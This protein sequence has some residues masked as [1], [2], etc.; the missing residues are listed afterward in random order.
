[1]RN[2]LFKLLITKR[3]STQ[4]SAWANRK[5]LIDGFCGKIL[6]RSDDWR[7]S[8]GSEDESSFLFCQIYQTMNNLSSNLS[9]TFDSFLLKLLD[10]IPSLHHPFLLRL[11]ISIRFF[12]GDSSTASKTIDLDRGHN[13]ETLVRTVKD[14]CAENLLLGQ[15]EN[16]IEY[17][18]L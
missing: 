13:S 1:M 4:R 2:H 14:S 5:H 17:F 12:S 8:G 3:P 18:S 11:C 15:V 9:M 6:Q 10:P 16:L 7:R